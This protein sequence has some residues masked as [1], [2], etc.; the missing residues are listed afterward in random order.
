MQPRWHQPG[1]SDICQQYS[2]HMIWHLCLSTVLLGTADVHISY[3]LN[4][5]ILM[6]KALVA[7]LTLVHDAVIVPPATF[8]RYL[9]AG[10]AL[11]AA[12]PSADQFP[13]PHCCRSSQ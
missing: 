8:V 12:A 7:A 1:L 6:L 9:P 13:A 11:Q 2:A 5:T 3:N 4:M 10:H